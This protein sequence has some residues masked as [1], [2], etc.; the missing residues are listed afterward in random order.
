MADAHKARIRQWSQ[1][2]L[3][4]HTRGE[5]Q[6]I[7]QSP[8]RQYKTPTDYRKPRDTIQSPQKTIQRPKILD[9]TFKKHAKPK[10]IEQDQK[11][12]QE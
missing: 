5:P 2:L 10:N 12:R 11:H 7:I 8:N 6:K 3:G 1:V 4:P 9:K